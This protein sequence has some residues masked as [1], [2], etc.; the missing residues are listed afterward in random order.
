MWQI[1]LG[2]SVILSRPKCPAPFHYAKHFEQNKIN[3]HPNKNPPTNIERKNKYRVYG[4]LNLR[5][6]IETI[7]F[8]MA[9]LN[10]EQFKQID[11][12]RA[13]RQYSIQEVKEL[14]K[15]IPHG[16][17]IKEYNGHHFENN[18]V[19][20]IPGDS[21]ETTILKSKTTKGKLHYKPCKKHKAHDPVIGDYSY[22]DVMDD[23]FK[24]TRIISGRLYLDILP[25]LINE[26]TL[27]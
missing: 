24:Q 6:L 18:H 22:W 17:R 19:K 11:E 5:C 3:T 9:Q 25:Q 20:F 23:E 13:K 12:N 16:I 4:E 7:I 8:I 27:D 14:F 2:L 21:N 10:E 1:L 26:L 15:L